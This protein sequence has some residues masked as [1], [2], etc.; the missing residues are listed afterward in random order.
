MNSL[1]SNEHSRRYFHPLFGMKDSS[2]EFP[3]Y[4]KAR[5][6]YFVKGPNSQSIEF[7]QRSQTCDETSY[8]TL[9]AHVPPAFLPQK[10]NFC[11]PLSML[12]SA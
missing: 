8:E 7:Q 11:F 10:S 9:M 1:K 5:G 6:S 2:I 3:L 4:G 12:F